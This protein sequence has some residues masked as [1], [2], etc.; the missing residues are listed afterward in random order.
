V[1][2]TLACW[3]RTTDLA[4]SKGLVQVGDGT[5]GD[6]TSENYFALITDGADFLRIR[7]RASGSHSDAITTTKHGSGTWHHGCAVSSAVDSRAI[8]LDGGGKGTNAVSRTPSGIDSTQLGVLTHGINFYWDGDIAEAAIWNAALTD[9]EVATLAKGYSPLLIRP[10]NLVFY[11]PLI[12]D[13]DEDIV[14]GLSLSTGGTPTIEAHPR[15][16]YPVP[17]SFQSWTPAHRTKADQFDFWITDRI[18]FDE[19]WATGAEESPTGPQTGSV[20]ANAAIQRTFSDSAT[21]DAVIARTE[22]DSVTADATVLVTQSASVTADAAIQASQAD[23]ATADAAIQRTFSGSVTSDALITLAS[24]DSITA[25]AAILATQVDS[26]TTDAVIFQ[27][28]IGSITADTAILAGQTGSIT[29]DASI[30][31]GQTD[32]I[33]VDADI[34]CIGKPTWVSPPDAGGTDSTPVLVFTIPY[35]PSNIHFRL[36]LDTVVTFDSGDYQKFESWSDQTNWEYDNGASWQPFPAGGVSNIYAG[37]QCRYSI[38]SSL[39]AG[40]WYR[41]VRGALA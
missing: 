19:L 25:D 12:R 3:F 14:G 7:T 40:T 32:S 15:I 18:H 23:S 31:S 41:V 35:A 13:A 8:Y 21:A 29:A 37:N 9:A 28:G 34:T 20:T 17:H 16:Y 5:V 39:D 27:T 2:L 11:V 24:V 30:G 26:I 33:T 22:T 4:D 10:A 36:E 1:P 6:G 38:S